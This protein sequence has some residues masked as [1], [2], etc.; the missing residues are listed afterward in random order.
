[1]PEAMLRGLGK[2]S[3]KAYHLSRSFLARTT[4]GGGWEVRGTTDF[5]CCPFSREEN[6]ETVQDDGCRDSATGKLGIL[7]KTSP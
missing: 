3:K 7:G 4:T 2:P 1:M 5:S 6:L